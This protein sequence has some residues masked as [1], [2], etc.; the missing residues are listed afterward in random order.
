MNEDQVEENIGFSESRV[1]TNDSNEDNEIYGQESDFN[2]AT[3]RSQ[4]YDENDLELNTLNQREQEDEDSSVP[5]EEF[6]QLQ[7]LVLPQRKTNA[8]ESIY[9]GLNCCLSIVTKGSYYFALLVYHLFTTLI[10]V[11]FTFLSKF[12]LAHSSIVVL[13]NNITFCIQY[14]YNLLSML[15][16]IIKICLQQLFP[17][18]R[19]LRELFDLNNQPRRLSHYHQRRNQQR[20]Q[21]YPIINL[22]RRIEREQQDREQCLVRLRRMSPI[23]ETDSSQRLATEGNESLSPSPIF[24]VNRNFSSR[25][26]RDYIRSEILRILTSSNFHPHRGSQDAYILRNLHLLQMASVGRDFSERDYEMLTSLDNTN[27]NRGS[28]HKIQLLISQLP[29]YVYKA[30]FSPSKSRD[31]DE[32]CQTENFTTC[33][34]QDQTEDDSI[35]NKNQCTICIE[36]FVDEEVIKILPCFHQF[37]N[38]CIDDWLLRKT[39][40]PVCKFDIKTQNDQSYEYE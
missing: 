33:A 27:F 18:S 29:T 3:E 7:M 30:K 9:K 15:F 31:Q 26:R 25:R 1:S 36:N 28:S 8:S 20:R 38:S 10:I 14:P 35:S 4:V 16:L 2:Q 19:E 34:G 22:N 21:Q 23:D 32:P 11:T 40:C 39:L 17:E 5:S 13:N 6:R 24:R 12:T 37:H